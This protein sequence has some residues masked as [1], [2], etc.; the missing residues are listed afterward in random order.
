MRTID[1]TSAC[2][3]IR[4]PRRHST[5]AS[6]QNATTA[7]L[8]RDSSAASAPT[9]AAAV[10]T[11]SPRIEPD[12]STSST[13]ERA[14]AIRSR[15]TMSSSSTTGRSAILALPAILKTVA[16]RSISSAPPR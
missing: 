15:T 5:A 13:T 12:T 10:R 3:P 7:R 2:G 9:V 1:S 4:C 8:S 11:R 6:D 14:A 16:S